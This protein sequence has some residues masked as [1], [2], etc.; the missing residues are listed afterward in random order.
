[1][2]RTFGLD[3]DTTSIASSMEF[4]HT[5]REKNKREKRKEGWKRKG[6][7]DNCDVMVTTWANQSRGE[8]SSTR[9]VT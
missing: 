2:E 4:T 9:V 6:G 5:I 1:M 3:L 8:E 7:G